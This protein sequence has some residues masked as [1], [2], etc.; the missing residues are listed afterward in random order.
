MKQVLAFGKGGVAD[1]LKD[2][3]SKEAVSYHW[4]VNMP[5]YSPADEAARK[6]LIRNADLVISFDPLQ[7]QRIAEDC[8][9][10]GTHLVTS[11][12]INEKIMNQR[13]RLDSSNLLFLYEMGFDPGLDHMNALHCINNIREQGGN[14]TGLH[15]HSGRL[16]AAEHDD[17]P[18]HFK[19]SD[20]HQLIQEGKRGAVYKDK[21]AIVRLNYKDIFDGSRLAEFPGLGFL[22]WYPVTDSMGYIP[23]Y[24]L[25]NTDT[26]VRTTLRH[27]DFMYG[28]KNVADL[29][30]TDASP[31][32]DTEGR[33]LA[34]FFRIHF[35]KYG[36]SGWLEKKMMERFT[37]T[38]DIL[39]KLMQFMEV[40]EQAIEGGKEYPGNILMVDEKGKLENI[41]L[42]AVKDKA[43]AIVAYKMHEANL[44]LKQ[45]FFLGMDDQETLINKGQCSAADV[46]TMALKKKISFNPGEHDM[47]VMMHEIEYEL[48]GERSVL[49]SSLLVKGT[50]DH[51]ATDTITGLMLGIAAKLVLTAQINLKG[52]HIPMSPEIYEPVLSELRRNGIA[53]EEQRKPLYPL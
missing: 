31:D 16:V 28:W 50:D 1:V 36:F 53:F 27:P 30:L 2:F 24:G 48:Q 12:R 37:Q 33:S 25:Y 43:A 8:I 14:I 35:E 49:T 46:L 18:W 38:K 22:G 11:G 3:L 23:L 47:A 44:T 17:N 40:E 39:E 29:H 20:P 13:S 32:Y 26:V 21:G 4:Q 52:L 41:D 34:D 19:T 7:H 45:L 6:E 42:D 9:E 10:C 5:E 15:S 51:T